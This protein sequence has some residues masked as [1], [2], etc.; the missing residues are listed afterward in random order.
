MSI[1]SRL[2]RIALGTCTALALA[3]SACAD[4]LDIFSGV[5]PTSDKPNV[6][7]ILDSSANWGASISGAPACYYR[8]GGVQ[9][10]PAVGPADQGT[11]LGVEQC[12]LYNLV[13]GLAVAST[14]GP[15]GDALFN[16]AIMLMN[17]SPNSGSYPRQ[18]FI[19][20]TTNSKAALKLKIASF[21]RNTDKAG[22]ADYGLAM[23]EAY[24]YYKGADRRNGGLGPAAK[25]DDD[26][27]N[28][29][30]Y[31]S[32]SSD[33]CGRNYVILIGNGSPQN[34]SAEIPCC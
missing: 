4:D 8:N 23:Y 28:G 30:R 32:P 1:L 14:G 29:S 17:E 10:T 22:N 11:K 19:A 24:L 16:V 12:A 2:G 26:A 7:L 20:L 33:S 34:S 5:S 6:L 25:R 3:T 21:S 9:I 31:L 15:N 18:A 27:F 13:D